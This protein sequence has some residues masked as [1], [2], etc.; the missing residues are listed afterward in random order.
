MR[1]GKCPICE[2]DADTSLTEYGMNVNCSSCGE[3]VESISLCY[4]EKPQ[5]QDKLASYLYYN[6]YLH[7]NDKSNK[8]LCGYIGSKEGFEKCYAD[9]PNCC[10]ITNEIVENWYPKTFEEKIDMFL[11]GLAKKSNFLGEELLFSEDQ[12][13][14]ACF[15]DRHPDG[16]MKN[17]QTKKIQLEYF[18]NYLKKNE[19]IEWKEFTIIILQNGWNRI[20][21][22]QKNSADNSKTVFIAM[23]FD[24]EMEP[25]KE[26]IKNA[27]IECGYIPRIMNEI[28]HNN[29]IVPEML[30]EIKKSRFLIAE[31][32]NHNNGAYYEAGYALGFGKDVI[33]VCK[34]KTFED[35]GHFDVKQVNTILWD[36]EDDLQE[37]LIKRIRATIE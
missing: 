6:V 16:P 20:D 22:L 7:N 26:A 12:I 4:S 30:Y 8:Y 31:L 27:I 19:F 1:N 36:N 37:K 33:H 32:T 5:N 9:H 2:A 23:S 35:D 13:I 3:F 24:K 10:H 21:E 34:S 18:L 29:Q 11:L 15:V 14:S 25:V 17:M 28:Q